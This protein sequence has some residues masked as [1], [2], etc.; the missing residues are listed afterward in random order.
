LVTANLPTG[1]GFTSD[2]QRPDAPF[3]PIIVALDVGK[4]DG[5]AEA[6]TRTGWG[7]MALS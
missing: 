2:C 7:V 1:A 4:E 6:M 3:G 5:A